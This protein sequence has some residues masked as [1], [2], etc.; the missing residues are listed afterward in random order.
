MGARYRRRAPLRRAI[1][2]HFAA[3]ARAFAERYGST[4]DDYQIWD[5]PN[6]TAAW[7]DTEPRPPIISRC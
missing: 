6:L 3:F 1:P 2:P 5:E 4:I 7:G